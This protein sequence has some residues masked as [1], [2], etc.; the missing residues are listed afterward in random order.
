MWHSYVGSFCRAPFAALR[1][2]REARNV[3][4]FLIETLEPPADLT[5]KAEELRKRVR[6]KNTVA[7]YGTAWDS[8]K[9]FCTVEGLRPM[10]A[11]PDTVAKYIA[12]LHSVKK[13]AVRTIKQHKA[14]IR[15]AHLRAAFTDPSQDALVR[16]TWKGVIIAQNEQEPKFS[17]SVWRRAVEEVID[18]LEAELAALPRPVELVERLTYARDRALVL[19]AASYARMTTAE[20]RSLKV[21][22]LTDDDVGYAV[23]VK[24]SPDA[25]VQPRVARIRYDHT[26]KYCPV[27]ALD[28]WLR[29]SGIKPAGGAPTSRRRPEAHG[30]VFRP[31]DQHGHLGRDALSAQH[32]R[33][34]IQRRCALAGVPEQRISI[35]ALRRGSMQQGAYDGETDEQIV[36]SAGLSPESMPMIAPLTSAARSLRKRNAAAPRTT[37]EQ[38]PIY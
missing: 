29:L 24:R 19:V 33:K 30:P 21:E 8:F 25:V 36:E 20:L 6:R 9:A 37:E 16:D 38:T 4:P 22:E 1:Q 27:R 10:P 15:D 3:Q 18:T 11:A 35:R 7:A 34:I 5:A 14:A 31:I 28:E 17:L 2:P 23:L 32:L 13:F 12:H 26:P